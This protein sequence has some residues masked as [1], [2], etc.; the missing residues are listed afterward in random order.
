MFI[1]NA[2]KVPMADKELRVASLQVGVQFARLWNL[3]GVVFAC[4]A[5]LYCP[6]LVQF[7]KN[8]GLVCASYGLLNNEPMLARVSFSLSLFH[9]LGILMM[10]VVNRNKRMPA[11]I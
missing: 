9:I 4:E 5:L 2:G 3:A 6:R 1:T 10:T 7:V 8:A 11:W